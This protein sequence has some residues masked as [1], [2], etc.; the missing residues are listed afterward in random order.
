MY[1]LSATQYKGDA[2]KM[3]KVY[4]TSDGVN[5]EFAGPDGTGFA[6]NSLD[7]NVAKSYVEKAKAQFQTDYLTTGIFWGDALAK[8]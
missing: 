6:T 5:S 4:Y 7:A 3:T 2:L 1:N 8:V